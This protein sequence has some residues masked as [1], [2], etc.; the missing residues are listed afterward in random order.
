MLARRRTIAC[1]PPPT[2]CRRRR[3][4]SCFA[5]RSRAKVTGYRNAIAIP[6]ESKSAPVSQSVISR[7]RPALTPPPARSPAPPKVLASHPRVSQ[8]VISYHGPVPRSLLHR[9]SVPGSAAPG[10]TQVGLLPSTQGAGSL[11]LSHSLSHTL[12]LDC[13]R[14]A[15]LS[16][17]LSLARAVRPREDHHARGLWS[18]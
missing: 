11:S 6:E 13:E 1:L 12:S 9:L 4:P 8:S 14:V 2:R 15:S 10:R 16:L 18:M 7:S 17:S 5:C 3:R